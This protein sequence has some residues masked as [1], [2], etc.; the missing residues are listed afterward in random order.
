MPTDTAEVVNDMLVE[1]F[2]NVVDY[3]FTAKMEEDLDAIAEGKRAWV[4]VIRDF[5]EPFHNTIKVKQETLKKSDIV[6]EET[7]EKVRKMRIADGN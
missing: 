3:Q 7:A 4:P 2:P 1:H 5:Y 6:N